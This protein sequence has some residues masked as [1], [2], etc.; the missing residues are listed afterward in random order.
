MKLT[1]FGST[2]GTGRQVVAQAL[3]QEHDVTAFARS[4][5]KVDQTHKNLQV[6][7]RGVM[8]LASAERAVQ[9]QDSVICTLGSGSAIR[10]KTMV[11]ANGMK[12]II[13]AMEKTSVK[14]LICQSSAGVVD[15]SD[16][17]PF[18]MK[19]LTVPFLLRRVFA[20]HEIQENSVKE[21]Q[22]DWI[23]RGTY[24]L[25]PARLYS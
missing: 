13:C 8:N 19:Y 11:R 21:S 14:R 9:G 12:N 6:I 22:L 24:R 5:E 17:L 18:L 16:T 7:Q 20:D 15:S 1:I 4:P 10:E 23:I 2:G 3:A 25:L